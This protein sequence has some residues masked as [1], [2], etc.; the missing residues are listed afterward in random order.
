MANDDDK[1]ELPEVLFDIF[2]SMINAS[3]LVMNQRSVDKMQSQS[4]RSGVRLQKLIERECRT[5]LIKLQNA[6][7]KGFKAVAK[8]IVRLEDDIKSKA[9]KKPPE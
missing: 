4:R 9:D 6:T 3:G 2:Y 7:V 1:R 8:D 5:S